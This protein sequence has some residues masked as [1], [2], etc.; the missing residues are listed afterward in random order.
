[1]PLSSHSHLAGHLVLLHLVPLLGH[2]VPLLGYLVFLLLLL[3]LGAT[4]GLSDGSSVTT[5]TGAT[6]G[7]S[8][9][10]IQPSSYDQLQLFEHRYEEGYDVYEDQDNLSWLEIHPPE[11]LPADRYSLVPNE[12]D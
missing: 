8:G 12:K 11:V 6:P 5:P 9:E 7:P 1:M 2:L 10:S 3:H 4:P